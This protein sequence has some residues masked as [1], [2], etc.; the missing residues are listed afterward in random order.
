MLSGLV[1]TAQPFFF[2]FCHTIGQ[3]CSASI[4][5]LKTSCSNLV[6]AYFGIFQQ[7]RTIYNLIHYRCVLC[8]HRERER[9]REGEIEGEIWRRG[10]GG[11]G[12]ENT[13]L[14]VPSH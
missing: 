7:S 5:P 9:N 11:G 3:L 13:P 1:M 6:A 8:L 4:E 12:G 10:G 2:S 14:N